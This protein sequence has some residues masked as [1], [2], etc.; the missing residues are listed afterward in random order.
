[1]YPCPLPSPN[2]N[3][4]SWRWDGVEKGLTF[5]GQRCTQ[6]V[7]GPESRVLSLCLPHT[8]LLPG[9]LLGNGSPRQLSVSLPCRLDS[10]G[11]E[12]PVILASFLQKSFLAGLGDGK[13][14]EHSYIEQ[15]THS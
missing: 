13:G 1:M 12:G 6:P 11:L 7:W 15:G 8:P 2:P 4:H 3:L 10:F 5:A 9:T 14:Q